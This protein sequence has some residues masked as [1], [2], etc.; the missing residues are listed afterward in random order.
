M[1]TNRAMN[2]NRTLAAIF[3]LTTL[4][5]A[6]PLAAQQIIVD[7]NNIGATDVRRGPNLT[8]AGVVTNPVSNPF[9]IAPDA[10]FIGNNSQ[11]ELLIADGAT[12][13]TAFTILGEASAGPGILTVSGTGS[14]FDSGTELT[15]LVGTL[16]VL[17]GGMLSTIDVVQADGTML[18]DGAG[19][20]VQATG[21][22]NVGVFIPGFGSND[23]E[24]TI[25]DGGII[26][27]FNVFLAQRSGRAETITVNG[28]GS[29][30]ISNGPQF[31][32]GP[33]S[34]SNATLNVLN[35]A[36]VSGTNLVIGSNDGLGGS[37]ARVIVDG[38]GSVLVASSITAG[39]EGGRSLFVRSGARVET[40]SLQLGNITAPAENG[41]AIVTDGGVL[42]I[43]TDFRID[44]PDLRFAGGTL[45]L[46]GDH[47]YSGLPGV[48]AGLDAVLDPR[49]GRL[50]NN[51]TLKIVG[52][53]DLQ[54]GLTVDGATL[55]A[56]T[57]TNLAGV[58]LV[59]GTLELTATDVDITAGGQF[60]DALSVNTNQ[61]V[62]VTQNV[63]VSTDGRVQLGGGQ[64]GTA[65]LVNRGLVSGHGRIDG[66]L[67]NTT[68]GEV[69]VTSGDILRIAGVSNQNQGQ[70]RLLGD[71]VVEFDS[72]L[73][74]VASG[75]IS[76]RGTIITRDGL[77]NA[78]QIQLS[79]GPT[80]LIGEVDNTGVLHVAGNSIATF[81]DDFSNS[82]EL[83]IADG[84][85]AVFF[86]DSTFNSA[87]ALAVGIGPES[88]GLLEVFG[89]LM[90][91]GDL[92][93]TFVDG[94]IPSLGDRYT[95][96]EAA[97]NI[98]G[99]FDSLVTSILP[100]GLALEVNVLSSAVE[101][102]VVQVGP[103][104]SGDFDL[105]GDV[106]GFDFLFW[107]RDPSTGNLADWQTNYGISSPPTT[108]SAA[109]PEPMSLLLAIGA[110]LFCSCRRSSPREL[111]SVK[112]TLRG[113]EV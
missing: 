79:G 104:L 87:S 61:H 45:S 47:T 88:T 68:S 93:V 7:P 91:D 84:S 56:G 103:G 106:D 5:V 40:Q 36:S 12:A 100:S 71:S 42:H 102:E 73:N 92:D 55:S 16:N 63:R 22:L 19:S 33:S 8:F 6:A 35:G 107:Q 60:G 48:T 110:T 112:S 37:D 83:M 38:A 74:N 44:S 113:I 80:D 105:D 86:A 14:T 18:V 109:V 20:L 64:L 90:L 75:V 101:I 96:A 89:D 49:D 13:S 81:Y 50:S 46:G 62:Q 2:T 9:L 69:R 108:A 34:G 25:S 53:L 94:M 67:L 97:G 4:S 70:I 10:L 27:V 58:D 51:E 52:N 111:L 11:G 57:I 65:V 76:G 26:D 99:M 30:L 28:A 98:A 32:V 39:G 3:W 24:V 21:D 41:S 29:Q 78:G 72:E 85:K 77:T 82:G 15:N 66:N 54:T 1:K 17:D 59:R 43:E 31:N 23:S 95:V